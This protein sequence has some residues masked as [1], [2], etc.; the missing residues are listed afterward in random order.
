[1]VIMPLTLAGDFLLRA[2]KV[3]EYIPVESVDGLLV[4]VRLPEVALL[5][6]LSQKKS[7]IGQLC[8]VQ[9]SQI[10]IVL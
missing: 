9:S 7:H 8:I 1:M 5:L 4:I 6:L 3:I 2:A 10:S